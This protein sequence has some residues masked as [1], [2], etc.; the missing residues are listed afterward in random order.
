MNVNQNGLNIRGSKLLN[1]SE[2][3]Y[4]FWING[5]ICYINFL[6]DKMN[7]KQYHRIH[8]YNQQRFSHPI[9][10]KNDLKNI[11]EYEFY[12]KIITLHNC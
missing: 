1:N 9:T 6:D 12:T 3:I 10:D 8:M 4:N 11:E 2:N 7:D 5:Y